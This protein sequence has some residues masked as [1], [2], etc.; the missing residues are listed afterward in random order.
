MKRRAVRESTTSPDSPSGQRR[1]SPRILEKISRSDEMMMMI[2]L[3]IISD[4]GTA[5]KIQV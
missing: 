2:A 1:K 3:G 5:S 4:T